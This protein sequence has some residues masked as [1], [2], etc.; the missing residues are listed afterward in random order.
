[1]FFQVQNNQA[2]QLNKYWQGSEKYQ[3]T[4]ESILEDAD[5]YA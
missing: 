1:M 5:F 3:L 2:V 4:K